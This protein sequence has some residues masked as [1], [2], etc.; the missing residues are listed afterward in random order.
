MNSVH[1]TSALSY[2][3]A[4]ATRL[5]PMPDGYRHLHHTVRIGRGRAVFEAAGEAV[6][7]WHAHRATGVRLRTT[8]RRAEPGAR[9]E[10]SAGFGPLR[11]TAPCEVVW[12][13]HERDRTGFGYGTLRG[14]PVRG[15]E[16]FAVDL[17]DDG[18]V[19]FTVMA[20][21]RPAVWWARLGGPVVPLMQ[22]AYARRLGRTVRR[23]AG[24]DTG[25]DGVVRR[26]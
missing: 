8:A 14:H 22:T 25:G 13:V 20:F 24:T 18:S 16:S 4:G 26:Q 17:R 3:E 7:T 1:R 2:P 12:T 9:V 6:A 23:L 10:V 21:S 19:W 11:I 5:G 15:E